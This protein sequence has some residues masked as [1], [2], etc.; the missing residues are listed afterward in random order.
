MGCGADWGVIIELGSAVPDRV[1]DVVGI[2][3]GS[4]GEAVGGLPQ[5]KKV[6]ASRAPKI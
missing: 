1:G 2:K 4:A 3:A 5:A 6:K